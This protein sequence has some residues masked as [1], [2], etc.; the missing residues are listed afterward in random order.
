MNAHENPIA[1]R[2]SVHAKKE[3]SYGKFSPKAKSS[4]GRMSAE[5]RKALTAGLEAAGKMEKREPK[6][7]MKKLIAFAV[8]VAVIVAIVLQSRYESRKDREIE[9]EIQDAMQEPY[10]REKKVQAEALALFK[11]DKWDE[12]CKLADTVRITNPELQ[13]FMGRYYE[14]GDRMNEAGRYYEESAQQ[15]FAEAQYRLG[16]LYVKEKLVPIMAALEAF[17]TGNSE[18]YN[19]IRDAHRKKGISLYEKAAAQ[20]HAEALF[21][22]GVCYHF[23]KGVEKNLEKAFG[24]FKRAAELGVTSGLQN[25]GA[26][27]EHGLGIGKDEV[28]AVEWYKKGAEK[29]LYD[30]QLCLANMYMLGKGTEKDISK[31]IALFTKVA[32]KK[33]P[34]EVSKETAIRASCALASIYRQGDGVSEDMDKA[35]EWW[36]RAAIL[37]DGGSAWNLYETYIK[38]NNEKEAMK[39]L[40]IAADK[41]FQNAPKVYY[42]LSKRH[43]MAKSLREFNKVCDG[44]PIEMTSERIKYIDLNKALW[45]DISLTLD[46]CS[47]VDDAMRILPTADREKALAAIQKHGKEIW[48]AFISKYKDPTGFQIKNFCSQYAGKYIVVPNAKV[49]DAHG[50]RI[51][52]WYK[53]RD[54]RDL[55]IVVEPVPEY[56]L[57]SAEALFE[58]LNGPEVSGNELAENNLKLISGFVTLPGFNVSGKFYEMEPKKSSSSTYPQKKPS[59]RDWD[60]PIAF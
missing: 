2:S 40:K 29:N 30:S 19:N 25:V 51:Y 31:A 35:K 45:E 48:A 46:N 53:A 56:A 37:G 22:L 43:D 3:M 8:C 17:D 27:Y 24:F 50:E 60:L 55:L 15:G 52:A 11:A 54:T 44:F 59:K 12:A 10:I 6:T 58:A 47:D 4:L 16:T 9:R 38:W 13:C 23:G 33:V 28:K 39:W 57:N 14:K 5:A 36:K 26:C 34:E 18:H 49:D 20:D 1:G 42:T 41:Y 7:R 32:E 21:E